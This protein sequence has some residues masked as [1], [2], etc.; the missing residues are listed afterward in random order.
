MFDSLD[1]FLPLDSIQRLQIEKN[2]LGKEIKLLMDFDEEENSPKYE[3]ME[4]WK[5]RMESHR[6]SGRNLSSK[7]IIQAKLLLKNYS[8]YCPIQ[9]GGEY[10]GFTSF[11][12]EEPNA[13]S[14][15]WQDKCL[16][17]LSVWQCARRR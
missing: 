9:F 7:S 14:L 17:T 15:A 6:F 8:H 13:I 16:I 1:D 10:G 2:H 3:S 4:T 12:R 11:E 5:G